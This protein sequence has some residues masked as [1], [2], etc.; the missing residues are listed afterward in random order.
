M[1]HSWRNRAAA[2][3]RA[4]PMRAMQRSDV[5]AAG[6]ILGPARTQLC[7]SVAQ[8]PYDAATSVGAI[9]TAACYYT[10]HRAVFVA[11]EK[12]PDVEQK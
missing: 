10:D 11:I 5:V 1:A 2:A 12:Q 3:A 4:L 7:A 9:E 8:W 6:D